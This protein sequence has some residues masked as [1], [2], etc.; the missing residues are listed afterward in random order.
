MKHEVK[1]LWSEPNQNLTMKEHLSGL[2]TSLVTSVWHEHPWVMIM[3]VNGGNIVANGIHGIL[4]LVSW[5][6]CLSHSV[7]LLQLWTYVHLLM[8]DEIKY[9]EI[10]ILK[11]K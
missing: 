6:G 8:S 9:N 5:Y 10:L 11:I 3:E 4:W 2:K 7:W 1:K